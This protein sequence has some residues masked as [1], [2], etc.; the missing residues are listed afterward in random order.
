MNLSLRAALAS[1]VGLTAT[2]ALLFW[3]AGTFDYWQGWALI[4]V[5]LVLT[6]PYTVY[7]GRKQPD[8][9]RRRLRAGPTAES[10]GVQRLAVFGLQASTLAVFAVGGLDRRHGWTH[11]PT[12][13]CVVGLGLAGVGLGVA[14]VVVLQNSWAAAT[15]EIQAGQ[16]VVATGLYTVVRHPM[17]S[18]AVAMMLG[19][20]V[21]LGSYWAYLPAAGA[22]LALI[23]RIGDEERML[24]RDLPG[25]PEY[26]STVRYR[27][28][29]YLW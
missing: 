22:L 9:L 14:I 21:G 7:L 18:G 20:P 6:V 11:V 8:V 24:V 10:R 2:G 19:L 12:W 23:V 16:Q 15:V 28:V 13:L 3:P 26:R 5:M 17:Y 1:I 27:L 29:P 25:Y 4:A